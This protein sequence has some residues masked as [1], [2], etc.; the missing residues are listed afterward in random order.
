MIHAIQVVMTKYLLYAIIL[1]GLLM[2]LKAGAED[3][4]P[5]DWPSL[6]RTLVRFHAYDLT[7]DKLLDEY[8][9][10]TE[11]K[12]HESF[13]SDDFKWNQVRDAIRQSVQ[14]NLPAFPTH[15]RYE[16]TFELDRY[17]FQQ[18]LFRFAAKTTVKNVNAFVLLDI[19]GQTC[20]NYDLK[21]MPQ[22]FRGILD[23][24]LYIEGLSLSEPDAQALLVRMKAANNEK[25]LVFA[26][27]NLAITYIEPLRFADEKQGNTTQKEFKQ[28]HTSKHNVTM[29]VRLDSAEFFEDEARTKLLYTF[30]P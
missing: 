4:A 24:P 29:N 16:T 10:V 27:F 19:A 21:Y 18:Q 3:Y 28:A 22:N 17:D 25:R 8:A 6:A 30:T 14:Q 12:L 2:P 23:A 13:F 1:L 11:C 15:Y 26:R 7:D 5:V 20:N 9:V